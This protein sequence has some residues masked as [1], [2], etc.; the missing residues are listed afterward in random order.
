[1][2][3]LV[4]ACLLGENCKYNGGNNKDSGVIEFLQGKEVVPICPEVLGGLPTPRPCAEICLGEV[5]NEFGENVSFEFRKGVE[6]SMDIAKSEEIDLAIL[7]SKSPSC[8]VKQIYDGTFSRRLKQGQ[9]LLAK[10]LVNN[11]YKVMD[12]EQF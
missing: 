6:L 12:S 4:S 8:G 9:G 1:M 7:K 2:K 10:E 5:Y 3:V 11:G